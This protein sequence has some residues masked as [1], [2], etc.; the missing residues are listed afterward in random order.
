[1]IKRINFHF[2]I[3]R[4]RQLYL[5]STAAGR[6]S[7]TTSQLLPGC[8]PA[9]TSATRD[10][11]CPPSSGRSA[12]GEAFGLNWSDGN[13]IAPSVGLLVELSQLRPGNPAL[14]KAPGQLQILL[15][16]YLSL[17]TSVQTLPASPPCT[18]KTLTM[19][20]LMKYS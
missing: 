19:N 4:A 16:F 11:S 9:M 1:M 2:H 10:G 8:F 3:R 5:E 15:G 18:V 17:F 20:P 13:G 7:N 14:H 12:G 6:V